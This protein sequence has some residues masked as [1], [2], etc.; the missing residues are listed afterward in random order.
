MKWSTGLQAF[1]LC[2]LDVDRASRKHQIFAHDV[3]T[4]LARDI[5]MN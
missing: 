3:K 4:E 1:C 2:V 5:V